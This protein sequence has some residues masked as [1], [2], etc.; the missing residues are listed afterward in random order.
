[1]PILLII[2]LLILAGAITLTVIGLRN[3]QSDNDRAL[4][5]RLEEFSQTGEPPDLR[6]LELSQPFT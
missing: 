1:M 3:P 2:I 6:E 4:Q 5:A